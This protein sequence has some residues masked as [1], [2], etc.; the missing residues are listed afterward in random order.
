[1]WAKNGGAGH[2][3]TVNPNKQMFEPLAKLQ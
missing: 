2:A 3:G 1:L